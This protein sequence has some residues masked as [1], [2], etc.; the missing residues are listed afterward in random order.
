MATP[1]YD[2]VRIQLGY[3]TF[4]VPRKL[5]FALFEACSREDV[6]EI[7]TEWKNNGSVLLVKELTDGAFAT[8]ESLSPAQFHMG[9]IAWQRKQEEVRSK[10][11]ATT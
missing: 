11:D 9:R 3:K 5:A 6:F 8:I 2:Y 4:A 1:V 7:T 10:N